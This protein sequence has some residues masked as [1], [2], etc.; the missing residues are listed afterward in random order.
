M[1][2]AGWLFGPRILSLIFY[3]WNERVSV[4]IQFIVESHPAYLKVFGGDFLKGF[5]V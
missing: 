3:P 1:T 2:M 5:V 4:Y